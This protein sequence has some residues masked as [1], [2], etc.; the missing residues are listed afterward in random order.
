MRADMLG[1]DPDGRALGGGGRGEA[2]RQRT[3]EE[4]DLQSVHIAPV[5]GCRGELRKRRGA[6]QPARPIWGGRR[7]RARQ[8]DRDVTVARQG[9]AMEIGPRR[10]EVDTKVTLVRLYI[11][12][13]APSP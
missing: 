10:C 4:D 2:R 13:I 9:S 5:V 3:G 1:G 11:W 8:S 6:G 12:H 7:W